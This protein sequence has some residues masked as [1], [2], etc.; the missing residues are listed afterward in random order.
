M[1]HTIYCQVGYVGGCFY[2]YDQWVVGDDGGSDGF[3]WLLVDS[4]TNK[5]PLVPCEWALRLLQ[6]LEKGQR[7]PTGMLYR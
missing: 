5:A 4:A 2:N 3:H 7:R 1:I 6:Q